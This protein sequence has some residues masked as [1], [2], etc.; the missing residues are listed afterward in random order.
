[1]TTA[2]LRKE[3]HTMI[4]AIPDQSLPAIKPLLTYLAEDYWKPVIEQASP[5]EIAMIDEQ[6]KDYE[7]NPSSFIPLEK[8]E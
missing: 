4:D 7:K 8:I 2:I 1:M 5:E 3:L 6:M